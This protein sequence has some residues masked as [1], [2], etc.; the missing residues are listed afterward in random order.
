MGEEVGFCVDGGEM[1]LGWVESGGSRK[2]SKD[3][4]RGKAW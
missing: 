4:K 2:R 1:S 3:G